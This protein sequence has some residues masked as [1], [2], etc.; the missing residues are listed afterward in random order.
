MSTFIQ[1]I[2]L[3]NCTDRW[4]HIHEYRMGRTNCSTVLLHRCTA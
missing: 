3:R 2:E 4:I 1:L